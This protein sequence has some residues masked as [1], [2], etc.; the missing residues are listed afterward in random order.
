[1]TSGAHASARITPR[2]IPLGDV[3]E[4]ACARI[5]ART[6]RNGDCIEWTGAKDADGYGLVFIRHRDRYFAHRLTYTQAKGPMSDELTIDHLCRNRAC[7]NPEHLEAVAAGVNTLRG[8][9]PSAKNARKQRCKCGREYVRVPGGDRRCKVCL[10]AVNKRYQ[11][12]HRARYATRRMRQYAENLASGRCVRCW[13]P[14]DQQPRVQCSS[15]AA[16]DA[17]RAAE[18]RLRA[19]ENA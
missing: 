9:S 14:N 8:E 4:K 1:M 11:Q 2:P 5:Y 15:C 19:K 12:K 17:K 3:L 6:V 13:Q 7:V 10:A 18:R 16:K